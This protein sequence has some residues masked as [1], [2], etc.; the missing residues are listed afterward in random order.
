MGQFCGNFEE[1]LQNFD[2]SKILFKSNSYE[3]ED[4]IET[5][6]KRGKKPDS[7]KTKEQIDQGVQSTL[8]KTIS[9]RKRTSARSRGQ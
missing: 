4:H 6:K 9:I 1:I 7:V 2:Y 8:D 5:P 3:W